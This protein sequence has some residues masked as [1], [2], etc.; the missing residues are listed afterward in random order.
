MTKQT[1]QGTTLNKTNHSPVFQTN[2]NT[3][4]QF[5]SFNVKPTKMLSD[6]VAEAF[7]LIHR[8]PSGENLLALVSVIYKILIFEISANKWMVILQTFKPHLSTYAHKC[9]FLFPKFLS[10]LRT[11]ESESRFSTFQLL[12]NRI[13]TRLENKEIFI[14]GCLMLWRCFQY[15]LNSLITRIFT[16]FVHRNSKRRYYYILSMTPE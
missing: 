6:P 14:T 10:T 3:V 9:V 13:K 4:I 5:T 8:H 1:F 7:G 2:S 11:S 16:R 15:E 12:C